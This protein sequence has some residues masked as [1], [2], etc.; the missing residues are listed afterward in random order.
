NNGPIPPAAQVAKF[1][2]VDQEAANAKQFILILHKRTVYENMTPLGGWQCRSSL[3]TGRA[4]KRFGQRTPRR[5]SKHQKRA[6]TRIALTCQFGHRSSAHVR[7]FT[8]NSDENC[9]HRPRAI[10]RRCELHSA[11]HSPRQT[12]TTAAPPGTQPASVWLPRE[13][14]ARAT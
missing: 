8:K 13:L 14:L 11:S 7:I 6:T 9:S 12:P 10:R 2:R 5:N 4:Q 1:R 3:Y